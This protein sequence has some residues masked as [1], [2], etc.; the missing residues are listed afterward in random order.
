MPQR[1]DERLK[2]QIKTD[3]TRR[4]RLAAELR[5][6]LRKR[7]KQ[8]P[9]LKDVAGG[10]QSEDAN[11]GDERPETTRTPEAAKRPR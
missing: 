11:G 1:P 4:E 8:V 6:N 3:R 5:A 2:G 7:K 9:G 10:P